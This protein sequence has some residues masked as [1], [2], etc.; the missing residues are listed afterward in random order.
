MTEKESAHPLSP[1]ADVDNPKEIS[2]RDSET[3][4]EESSSFCKTNS[5]VSV[6]TDFLISSCSFFSFQPMQSNDSLIQ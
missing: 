3:L 1:S 5:I 2:R 6:S 4:S